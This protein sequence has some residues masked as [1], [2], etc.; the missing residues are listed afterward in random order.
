MKLQVLISCMHQIDTSIIERTNI[1][2]DVIVINQ[3]NYDKRE[4]FNFINKKGE[5]CQ[6]IF[7]STT[8][9]GLSRSRNLALKNATADICLIC[10]DDE[11]LD[12]NYNDK[13]IQNYK[14]KPDLSIIA[15]QIKDSEKSYPN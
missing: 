14:N 3:C 12:D 10:D 4:E 8:E 5:V 2:T 11:V 1:Q 6:A 13:I 7:I 9:R 15:F